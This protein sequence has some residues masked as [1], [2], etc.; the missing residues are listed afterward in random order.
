[1]AHLQQM[2]YCKSVVER[3]PELFTSKDSEKRVLDCGSLDIN[4]NN[5]FMFPNFEYI[6]IDVAEGKNVDV[7]STIHEYSEKPESFD[8]IVSTECFEHDMFYEKSLQNIVRLLKSGGIFVF[9]CATTGRPVHGTATTNPH[10]SPLLRDE[11]ANYYKNITEQD[12]RK[13]I[14]IES[15]FSEH[16]FIVSNEARMDDLYFYGIK[17]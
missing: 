17:K 9:T 5:R 4:G 3:F 11:W 15:I 2:N 13:A 14:D 7:V 12:V 8:A 1:M 10:L 6:G 16:E